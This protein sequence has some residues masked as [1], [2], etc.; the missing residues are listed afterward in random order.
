LPEHVSADNVTATY[1]AGVLTVR[2]SGVHTPAPVET[3]TK[4]A[5]SSGSPAAGETAAE[6][7]DEP[8]VTS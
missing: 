3:S 8:S 4:V 5:I 1:D 6:A 2:V 7:T